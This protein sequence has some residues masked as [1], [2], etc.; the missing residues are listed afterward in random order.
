MS[1]GEHTEA[2]ARAGH[3]LPDAADEIALI[4]QVAGGDMTAF[5]TLFRRYYPRLRRFLERMT[6]R[7]QLVDEILNALISE[8]SIDPRRVYLLGQSNGGGGA[9]NL[10][11]NA[12]DRFAAT[13]LV[14]P[15]VSD[16]THA[17]SRQHSVASQSVGKSVGVGGVG[18][19]GRHVATIPRYLS[20]VCSGSGASF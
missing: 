3:R 16:V 7:P 8:F 12:P 10:V 15:V 6:R 14:C 4:G 19:A 9:W 2:K 18:Q 5:E 1:R 11:T 13:V 17:A 20:N